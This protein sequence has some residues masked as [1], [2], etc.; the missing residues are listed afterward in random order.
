MSGRAVSPTVA[1]R[2]GRLRCAACGHDLGP[3]SGAWKER[4]ARRERPL[5]EAGGPAW[6]TGFPGVVL[7]EFACPGCAR[8]LDTE[9]ARPEDPPLLDRLAD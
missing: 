5:A 8:L 1:A 7:R 6:D 9:T 3:A 4:A 2:D